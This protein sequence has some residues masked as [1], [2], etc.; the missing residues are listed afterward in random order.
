MI[1]VRQAI[2]RNCIARWRKVAM[3]ISKVHSELS[4]PDDDQGYETV[5]AELVRLV[6]A[7]ELEAVGSLSDWR[8]SEVRLPT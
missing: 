3:V 2:L 4:L 7:G 5:A 6:E 8:G 1:D